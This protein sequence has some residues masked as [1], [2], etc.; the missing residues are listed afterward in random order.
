M[1]QAPAPRPT[2]IVTRPAREAHAWVQALSQ[3]GLQALAQPLI[4]ILPVTGAADVARLQEA[5]VGMN[6]HAALMFVSANAVEGFLG[7]GVQV[8]AVP[9]WATGP[10]TA[11]ALAAAGVPQGLIVSPAADS[12][13]FDSEALWRLIDVPRL[14]GCSVLIV[15]G[16]DAH[17]APAGMADGPSRPG[18]GDDAAASSASSGEGRDWLARQLTAAGAQPC[19]VVAYLRSAPVLD[20]AALARLHAAGPAAVWLFSSAQ[21]LHNLPGAAVRPGSRAVATHPRI[22]QAARERGFVVRE[23]RPA[24]DDVVRS[25]ESFA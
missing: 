21:A 9:C 20:A 2:V 4:D 16:A 6:R 14:A 3:R 10:G 22:A 25:I 15:R 24:M 23:C 1:A 12:G 8:P 19:F 5:R 17:R 7:P 13:Q 18:P 11:A